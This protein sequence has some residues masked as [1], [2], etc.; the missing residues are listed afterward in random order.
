MPHFVQ[1]ALNVGRYEDNRA[2]N[3]NQRYLS[4]KEKAYIT[5]GLDSSSTIE[6]VKKQYRKLAFKYHPDHIAD[7]ESFSPSQK[8]ELNAQFLAIVQAY[9]IILKDQA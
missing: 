9:E 6:Q 3:N 8:Q 5:L 4:K 2:N 1:P 7:Y